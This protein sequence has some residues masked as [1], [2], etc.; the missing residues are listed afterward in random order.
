L[1][2]DKAVETAEILSNAA[3]SWRELNSP[4]G[5]RAIPSP[6]AGTMQLK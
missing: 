6:R 5:A 2:T 3:L 1:K 4:E